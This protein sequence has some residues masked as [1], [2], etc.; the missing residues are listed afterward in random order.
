MDFKYIENDP[1][2]EYEA[3]VWKMV[4][5]FAGL[6]GLFIGYIALWGLILTI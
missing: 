5:S 2:D 3:P 1:M 4:L 6:T